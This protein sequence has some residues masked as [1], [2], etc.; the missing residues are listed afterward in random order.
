MTISK[1][2]L[3]P[4]T[5]IIRLTLRSMKKVLVGLPPSPANSPIFST[6]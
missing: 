3:L 2:P 5:L 4:R 6:Q 1:K